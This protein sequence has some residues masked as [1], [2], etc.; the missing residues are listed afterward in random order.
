[1]SSGQW[2][3]IPIPRATRSTAYSR[4]SRRHFCWWIGWRAAPAEDSAC[5][6]PASE[7]VAQ[8]RGVRYPTGRT[9]L[10]CLF[11]KAQV[12]EDMQTMTRTT[13]IEEMLESADHLIDNHRVIENQRATPS[14]FDRSRTVS[15]L[16]AGYILYSAEC[17][18]DG[19]HKGWHVELMDTNRPYQDGSIVSVEGARSLDAALDQACRK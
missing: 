9:G 1:M 7:R 5:F 2:I 17:L 12:H 15:D 14:V 13:A 10:V 16:P 3:V 11:Q 19:V 6:G 18:L 4:F 8:T